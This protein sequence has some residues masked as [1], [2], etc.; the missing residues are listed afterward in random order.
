MPASPSPADRHWGLIDVGDRV[1]A[2]HHLGLFRQRVRRGS[3][4]IVIE[5]GADTTLRVRF[6]DGR[7]VDVD[8]R[9]IDL[10]E[11]PVAGQ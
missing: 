6:D 2:V 8:P 1:A 7:V 5:H 4:G 9:D 11:N 10:A 3:Q